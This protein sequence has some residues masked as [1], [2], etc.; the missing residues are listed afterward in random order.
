MSLG[1]AILHTFLVHFLWKKSTLSSLLG[2]SAPVASVPFAVDMAKYLAIQPPKS[3]ATVSLFPE[4]KC[5]HS[6]VLR[7]FNDDGKH[8]T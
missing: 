3:W 5:A 7:P 1:Q 4:Y 8:R 2:A 6:F